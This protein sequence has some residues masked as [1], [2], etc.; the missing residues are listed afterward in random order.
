VP[1]NLNIDNDI[2]E[3]IKSDEFIVSQ[4]QSLNLYKES[5]F[6]EDMKLLKLLKRSKSFHPS[7][8]D[9][10][11]IIS[12]QN[13]Q[14]RAESLADK[15]TLRKLYKFLLEKEI[16]EEVN[17]E[18]MQSKTYKQKTITL[19]QRIFYQNSYFEKLFPSTKE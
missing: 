7:S 13:L 10:S 11:D 4:M 5:I 9:Q 6:S 15:K 18:M 1:R 19:F 3:S 12:T 14:P 8:L 2:A 17:Q 16:L